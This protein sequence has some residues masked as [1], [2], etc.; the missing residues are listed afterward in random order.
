VKADDSDRAKR[1]LDDVQLT[2][3]GASWLSAVTPIVGVSPGRV[4]LTSG[5]CRK[6][7]TRP[8][9]A[10]DHV[11]LTQPQGRRVRP[12]GPANLGQ[13]GSDGSGPPCDRTRPPGRVYT[14]VPT[15]ATGLPL[16]SHEES[17]RRRESWL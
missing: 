2:G 6:G 17:G 13:S 9:R 7:R 3:H 14:T 15:L 8:T 16:F 11:P 10:E 1:A 12:A 4:Q 5:I